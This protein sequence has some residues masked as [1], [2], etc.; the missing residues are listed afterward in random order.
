M[1]PLNLSQLSMHIGLAPIWSS[2][3]EWADGADRGCRAEIATPTRR[4]VVDLFYGDDDFRLKLALTPGSVN[5]HHAML[6]GLLLH[7]FEAS[8]KA[9]DMQ[10]SLEEFEAFAS[11]GE[12][13]DKK[14]WRVGR[15]IWHR[16]D[17]SWES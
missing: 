3:R 13:S 8:A 17:G 6:G 15:K 9:N 5:G 14:P 16:P 2:Q 1:P 7:D 4:R 12:F 10:E 11:G